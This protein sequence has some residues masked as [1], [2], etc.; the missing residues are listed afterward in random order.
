MLTQQETLLGRG[1]WAEN[2]RM[3]EPGRNA[4]PCGLG[5]MLI[6]LI[7]RL[8]LANHSDSGNFLEAQALLSENGC[9]THP[10]R[11]ILG[12]GRTCSVSF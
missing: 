3:R 6:G 7:S 10:V 8:S 5:F 12:R 4:L 1:A 2:I 9:K 11:M